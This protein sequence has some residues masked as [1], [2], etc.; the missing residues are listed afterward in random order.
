MHKE[1]KQDLSEAIAEATAQA[2]SIATLQPKSG[3]CI[4]DAYIA[5]DGEASYFVKL[6]AAD[7]WPMFEA[8]AAAL[9]ELAAAEAIRVPRVICCGLRT[10]HRDRHASTQ[11]SV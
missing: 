3:G 1:L 10:S 2:C 7:A 11:P 4:N 6:N 8:E 5:S 9:R